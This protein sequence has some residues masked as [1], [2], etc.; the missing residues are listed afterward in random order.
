MKKLMTQLM[1]ADAVPPGGGMWS[2]V[3]FLMSGPLMKESAKRALVNASAAVDDIRGA[4][5][6]HTLG[7]ASDEESI[8]GWILSGIAKAKAKQAAERRAR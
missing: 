5:D 6:F 7:I 2:A 1:A 4:P 8:A 3:K